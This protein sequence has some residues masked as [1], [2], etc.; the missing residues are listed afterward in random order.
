MKL[1]I[2]LDPNTIKQ[3]CLDHVE[4]VLFGMVVI[5]F[6]L[7]V[8]KAVARPTLDWQPQD[9]VQD[10]DSADKKIESTQPAPVPIKSFTVEA[11]RIRKPISEADYTFKAAWDPLRFAENRRRGLPDLFPVKDLR[12]SAG[13]GQFAMAPE[14]EEEEEEEAGY[15]ST[16]RGQRW[17]VLTGLIQHLKQKQAYDTAYQDAAQWDY[18]RDYPDYIFFRVERAE[19]DPRVETAELKWTPIHVMNMLALQDLWLQPGGELVDPTLLPP[20]RGSVNLAY[21]L[22]PLQGRTWGPEAAH[23]KEIPILDMTGAMAGG[24]G[25]PGMYPGMPGMAG[26]K[27][28]SAGKEEP[29][30]DEE[31][32]KKAAVAKK[33]A[34]E[35]RKKAR[36]RLA[37]QPDEP[38][39]FASAATGGA[40]M[41]PGG[42]APGMMYPGMGR[43]ART[44]RSSSMPGEMMMPGSM[45][46][47]GSMMPGTQPRRRLAVGDQEE[48][49]EEPEVEHLLF[50]FF[51]FSVK[52]G[53]YYRYRVKLVLAN[54][55]F[56]MLSQFMEQDGMEKTKILETE[57]SEVSPAASVPVDS[58]VLAVSAKGSAGEAGL[59]LVRFNEDDGATAAEEISVQRGQWL[60][61]R[62]KTFKEAAQLG[63]AGPM[64]YTSMGPMPGMPGSGMMPGGTTRERKVDYLT[65][66]LLLDVAGGGRLPGK[67]RS[68]TEPGSV[69]LLDGE[70][71]LVVRNEIDDLPDY[72]FYKPP[73]M[74]QTGVASGGY[75]GMPGMPGYPGMPGEMPPP[76]KGKRPA[77]GS[78]AMP[79]G[80]T[81]GMSSSM[82][83][84]MPGPG[85]MGMEYLDD[86]GKGKKKKR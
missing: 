29:E 48:A 51:D 13:N 77:K 54:P 84:M 37:K 67:D 55:N 23:P 86:G 7:F 52:P 62:D 44:R 27:K 6:L 80:M 42:A 40:P 31:I 12:A 53:T 81:P 85:G 82:P 14:L 39:A 28:S 71:K 59:M 78:S 36:E 2:S 50:R 25:M 22:G 76:K 11:E 49:A 63:M 8:V 24:M 5:L 56:G 65:N 20:V 10:S 57:W 75:P 33:L 18:Q 41:G 83:G 34:A 43:P 30:S 74:K 47:S 68:L 72:N 15:V 64:S 60:D 26:K 16:M 21:P 3:F 32:E 70:G 58:R 79:P 4:K 45:P 61:Y 35:R 69:L 73:E 1:K 17:V 19:V 46:G 9:L 66:S 38:D